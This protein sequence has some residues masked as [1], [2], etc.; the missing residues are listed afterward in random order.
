[1][2]Q[3]LC[4]LSTRHRTGRIGRTAAGSVHVRL[5]SYLT[6]HVGSG[7]PRRLSG[8]SSCRQSLA[9]SLHPRTA[10]CRDP[11]RLRLSTSSPPPGACD[12]CRRNPSA[13]PD[14]VWFLAALQRECIHPCH[15]AECS[16]SE[17]QSLNQAQSRNS[18]N[19]PLLLSKRVV[20]SV[21]C[22]TRTRCMHVCSTFQ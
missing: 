17:V 18:I 20:V 1:M 19:S 7:Y 10:A 13:V 2:E 12:V 14:P 9:S 4:Q 22:T 11:R 6:V 21:L 15:R 16:R 3:C 5:R 8:R